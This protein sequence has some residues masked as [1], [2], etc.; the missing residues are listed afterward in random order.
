VLPNKYY[1]NIFASIL[2]AVPVCGFFAFQTSAV[3]GTH[4]AKRVGVKGI[5]T[6]SKN[7]PVAGAKVYLIESS[8]LDTTSPMTAVGIL[9]GTTETFDEP[10]EDIVRNPA[11]AALLPQATTTKNGRFS[12]P[13]I[14][15]AS[16]YYTFVQPA[17][18][19]TEHLPGGDLSRYSFYPNAL[20]RSG[21]HIHMSWRPPDSATYI[22]TSSCYSCH[23]F[24][25]YS[26]HAHQLGIQVPGQRTAHQDTSRF[27]TW[28]E[29]LTSYFAEATSYTDSGVKVLYYED[30]NAAASFDKFKVY[31]DI[32][33]GGTVYLKAYLWKTGT[34][35]K[36][37]LEN[38]LNP[39]DAPLTLNVKLTYGG[40][41]YRQLLLVDAPGRNGRYPFLQYQGLTDQRSSGDD[42]YYDTTRHVFRDY[43]GATFFSAGLDNTFGTAD[44]V[45]TLPPVTETF[46]GQCASCHFTGVQ[47]YKDSATH[48]LMATAVPDDNGAYSPDNSGIPQEVNVGCESCHGP[49][50]KH[51]EESFREGPIFGPKRKLGSNIVQPAYLSNDRASGICGQCHEQVTGKSQLGAREIPLDS[52]E[53]FP[54]PGIS[55][56]EFLTKHTTRKSF[57]LNQLWPDQT[58]PYDHRSQYSTWL[59]SKHARNDRILVACDD[60]HNSHGDSTFIRGLTDNPKDS[61]SRLCQRCHAID[62]TSHSTERAQ[63]PML[64]K[65]MKC[66]DCHMARTARSGAGNQG[67]RYAEPTGNATDADFLYWENDLVSHVMDV[68]RKTAVAGVQRGAAMPVPYYKSCGSCHLN[69]PVPTKP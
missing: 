37:T 19:D 35:Y 61:N 22:G 33:G 65:A 48:E 1:F 56:A 12:I 25:D 39:N 62:V 66:V 59:K 63:D 60:C 41:F 49:G 17:V 32:S 46:E 40:A 4:A 47:L 26:K 15:T 34:A 23:L 13:R 44:D 2:L 43:G 18:S 51:R 36:V 45:L 54:R 58:H 52:N 50:S 10:L 20:T 21:L 9:N 53:Q 67:L 30:Y 3:I 38:Q 42:T 27:P 24:Q 8:L 68:P 64:G 29:F 16:K 11:R 31:Q 5:V 14:F 7:R 55:R 6:D 57:A 28:D 69:T